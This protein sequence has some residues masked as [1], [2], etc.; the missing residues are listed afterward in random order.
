MTYSIVAR[1]GA[2]GELGV[3]VQ[4]HYLGVGPVVPWARP[5]VGAVA[6]QAFVEISYGP[7]LLELLAGGRAPVDALAELV[8]ADDQAESRQVAVVDATG[9]VAVHTGGRCIAEAGDRSGDGWSVQANMMLAPTVPDAMAEAFSSTTGELAVRLLAALDAAEAEGGDIRGR[10]SA[11]LLVVTGDRGTPAWDAVYD[12]RVDD[13]PDPLGELR[14]LVGLR[15]AYR[16]VAADD[17]V[18]GSNPELRFWTALHLAT[19]GR[20]DEARALLD[21][22]YEA[23]EGWRELVRRLPAAGRLPDDPDLVAALTD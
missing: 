18:L 21:R 6:T 5:G 13:H 7:R 14:R 1:D 22:V 20:V 4:S 3:A 17:P 11:A 2:T 19:S 15:R 16:T 12:V 8:A 23:G 10:Q 9:A